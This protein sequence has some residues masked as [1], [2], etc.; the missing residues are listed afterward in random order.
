MERRSSAPLFIV[1][2]QLEQGTK[3][4]MVAR[5]TVQ[6]EKLLQNCGADKKVTAAIINTYRSSVLKSLLRC[7]EIEQR[8]REA[9]EKG[10]ASFKPVPGEPAVGIPHVP[11]L[12]EDCQNFLYE[13]KNCL[14]DMLI[15]FNHLFGTDYTD[16]SEWIWKSQNH[17]QPVMEYATKKFGPHD[18]KTQFLRQMEKCN[19]PFITMR[20]AAEHPGQ[21][22]GTLIIS[23]ISLGPDRKLVPPYW[24]REHEGTIEYGPISILDDLRNGV[25]NLFVT[26]E[27]VLVMWAK[28]NLMLPDVVMLG[29]IPEAER[30]PGCPVKYRLVES[31]LAPKATR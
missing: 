13:F 17:P 20:N 11:N 27:D 24:R 26:C 18:I 29:V 12:T 25:H 31:P 5:L 3:N 10:I 30:N 9:Y 28:E 21:R 16:A 15:I 19:G 22:S 6:Q 14:R 23:D 1:Q 2:Q 8:V 4:P 7:A